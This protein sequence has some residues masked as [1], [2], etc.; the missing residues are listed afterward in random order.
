MYLARSERK[1]LWPLD[2]NCC[3]PDPQSKVLTARPLEIPLRAIELLLN[4]NGLL[5]FLWGYRIKVG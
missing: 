1:H 4:M 2:L 5:W 3:P